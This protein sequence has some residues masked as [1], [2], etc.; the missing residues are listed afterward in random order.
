MGLLFVVVYAPSSWG[1]SDLLGSDVCS[2]T[3]P[4]ACAGFTP[5]P[6]QPH[7]LRACVQSRQLIV[8]EQDPRNGLFIHS[9]L[10]GYSM[11]SQA[12]WLLE[13]GGPGPFEFSCREVVSLL[14]L[15][16]GQTL[17]VLACFWT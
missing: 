7:T 8:L 2:S 6:V 3:Q 10:L 12:S 1:P 11:A 9:L 4:A 5:E 17:P 16:L 13:A 15:H 14:P